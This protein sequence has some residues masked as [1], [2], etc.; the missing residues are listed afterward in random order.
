V[1]RRAHADEAAAV[2]ALVRAAFA[3]Y[4]PRTCAPPAPMLMDYDAAIAAGLVDVAVEAHIVTG[5]ILL[6]DRPDHLLL[7]VV[8]V[9]PQL[10]GRG[11]GSALLAHAEA[12]AARRHLPEIRLFTHAAMTE[13]QAIYLRRGYTETSRATSEG[14]PRVHYSKRIFGA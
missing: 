5:M 10:A 14:R 4:L 13:S 12:E 11:I 9:D 1:I 3:I 6:R 8:A 2:T 7:D